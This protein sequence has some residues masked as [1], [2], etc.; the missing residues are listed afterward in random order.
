MSAAHASLGVHVWICLQARHRRGTRTS[1]RVSR[2]TISVVRPVGTGRFVCGHLITMSLTVTLQQEIWAFTKMTAITFYSVSYA[3]FAFVA[4][5]W[6][7]A[8][9]CYPSRHY[10]AN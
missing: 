3:K 6:N 7:P 4:I 5:Q 8:K 1:G 10:A 2:T 9:L